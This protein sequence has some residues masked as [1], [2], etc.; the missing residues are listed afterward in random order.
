MQFE[1]EKATCFMKDREVSWYEWKEENGL[2]RKV[3]LNCE[4]ILK[5]IPQFKEHSYIKREQ[6]QRYNQDRIDSMSSDC[7]FALLRVDF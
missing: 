5:M 6:A 1:L 2:L 4:Y 3:L 7:N